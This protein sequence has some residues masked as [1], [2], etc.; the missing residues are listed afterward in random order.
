VLEE[1]EGS[2][3]TGIS[4]Y[5]ALNDDKNYQQKLDGYLKQL[6]TEGL[7]QTPEVRTRTIRQAEWEEQ[8]R[9]SVRP[10]RICDDVVVRPPWF[11]P[12]DGTTYDI[13]IEPRMA[14]GTGQHETTRSCLSAIRQHFRKGWSVLDL[15]CGSGILSVLADKMGATKITAI[16]YD[17]LA[18]D[19]CREN[20]E[21]NHVEALFEIEHGSIEKC[22]GDRSFDFVC[23][24]IIRD[25]IIEMLPRLVQ[26]TAK[27]GVLVLSG[28]LDRYETEISDGLRSEGLGRIEVIH[29][30]EWLTFVAFR[31]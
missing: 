30:N 18:V 31:D 20:F 28:I 1:E 2:A 3:T 7:P 13:I 4:F 29:D 8:Y 11:E 17:L 6:A 5:V 26:L 12:V 10:V 25:T 24:N 9:Q 23:A 19:N 15:G 14:F 16:D 27:G 22:D 21:V